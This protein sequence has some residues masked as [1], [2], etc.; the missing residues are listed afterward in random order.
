MNQ[1]IKFY[2]PQSAGGNS[3]KNQKEEGTKHGN[4]RHRSEGNQDNDNKPGKGKQN[5]N[6]VD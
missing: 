3:T 6:S 2:S 5:A 4:K 1:F